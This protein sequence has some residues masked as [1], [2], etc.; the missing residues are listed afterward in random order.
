[1]QKYKLI[2]NTYCQEIKLLFKKEDEIFHYLKLKLYLCNLKQSM[3]KHCTNELR[4]HQTIN[5]III[6]ENNSQL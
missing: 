1:M 2:F 5:Y 3:R 6:K 4:L